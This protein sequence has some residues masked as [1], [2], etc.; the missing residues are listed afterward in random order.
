LN[1]FDLATALSNISTGGTGTSV[2]G[3]Y[4]ITGNLQAG[5]FSSA[6]T[7][8]SPDTGKYYYNITFKN[9]VNGD[10]SVASTSLQAAI[11]TYNST[12][13]DTFKWNSGDAVSGSL[14]TDTIKDFKAWSGSSG[15]KL[16]ISDLL[17]G[18][19]FVSGTSALSDWVSFTPSSGSTAARIDI[20]TGGNSPIVQSIVLENANL[21]TNTT[22]QNL[23]DN[24]VL[25]A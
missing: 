5:W 20:D 7:T 18:L 22:L 9:S 21:G 3:K 10:I 1:A 8:L 11:T 2:A 4:T 23:L 6:I 14:S 15:D 16:D 12:D 13:N 17:R 25:V 24:R 19:G